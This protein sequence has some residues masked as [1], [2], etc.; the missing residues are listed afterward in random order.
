MT[1]VISEGL[2]MLLKDPDRDIQMLKIIYGQEEVKQA[3]EY[4]Q[5]GT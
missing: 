3:L 5:R 2:L 1:P 4:I